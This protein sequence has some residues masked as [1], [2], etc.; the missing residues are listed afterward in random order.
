MIWKKII[1]IGILLMQT[2]SLMGEA[3]AYTR[4]QIESQASLLITPSENALIAVV[5]KDS[6]EDLKALISIKNNMSH[7]ITI[8][9]ITCVDNEYEIQFK[10]KNTT[11]KKGNSQNITVSLKYNSNK[12]PGLKEI[13]LNVNIHAIWRGG[14]AQIQ[15]EL[16]FNIPEA[17]PAEKEDAGEEKI[18]E[19]KHNDMISKPNKKN[20]SGNTQN[21]EAIDKEEVEEN[22]N[23][24]IKKID[25]EA[26]EDNDEEIVEENNEQKEEEYMQ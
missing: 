2:A 12:N 10:N 18:K 11:I 14:S 25:N 24:I 23:E 13:K 15:Q 17:A 6:D 16:V 26:V 20:S 9:D 8:K 3:T 1:I 7:D 19:I 4:A 5:Q 21:I 22:D